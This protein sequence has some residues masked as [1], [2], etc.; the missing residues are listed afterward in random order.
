MIGFIL[1]SEGKEIKIN[2]YK[3]KNLLWKKGT[4]II[5]IRGEHFD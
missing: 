4:H 3:S 2:T 5:P 1:W